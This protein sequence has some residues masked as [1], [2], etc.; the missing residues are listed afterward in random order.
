MS[1]PL[2]KPLLSLDLRGLSNEDKATVTSIFDDLQSAGDKI[3]RAGQRWSRLDDAVRAQ[4]IEGVPMHY[5]EFLHRLQRIGEGSLHPQLYAAPGRAAATLGRLPMEAQERFLSERIPVAVVK[6]GSADVLKMD[7]LAMDD[8]TRRQVFKRTGD[9]LEIRSVTEQ[10][11]WIA[12]ENAKAT[13]K[14]LTDTRLRITRA[15]RWF[16]EKGRAYIDKDKA[17][18]GLTR[19]DCIQLMKDLEA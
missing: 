7:V 1:A 3:K 10:R 17:K 9:M 13:A 2:A 4:V 11:A 14:R 18:T 5:R 6:G 19:A 15:G 8:R 16:V 12:A